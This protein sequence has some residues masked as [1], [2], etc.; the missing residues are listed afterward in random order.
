[1]RIQKI[2]II[3]N[4]ICYG[5]EPSPKDEVEQ[6]LNISANGRV[7]FTGY[8]YASGFEKYKIGRKHQFSNDKSITE[9]MLTLFAQ[10]CESELLVCDATD[11]GLWK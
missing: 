5:A 8:N 4:N 2:R 10:Y 7:W 11:I 1:M 9:E 3:S 6:H